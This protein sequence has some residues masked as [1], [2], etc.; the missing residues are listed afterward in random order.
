MKRS[1]SLVLDG[2]H[3]D[4]TPVGGPPGLYLDPTDNGRLVDAC[5]EQGGFPRA[6]ALPNGRAV[7]LNAHNRPWMWTPGHTPKR[8]VKRRD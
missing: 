6:V 1:L 8:T 5:M 4:A 2:L 3:R 7:W